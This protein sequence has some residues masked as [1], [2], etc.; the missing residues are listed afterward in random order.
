MG[1]SQAPAHG[2]ECQDQGRRL[3]CAACRSTRDPSLDLPPKLRNLPSKEGD[4]LRM[5]CSLLTHWGR[6]RRFAAYECFSGEALSPILGDQGA[7]ISGFLQQIS[8][9]I[10]DDEQVYKS[11][12]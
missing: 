4:T 11:S 3:R 1:Q 8:I 6:R 5:F 7:E 10:F 9:V 12:I 2:W